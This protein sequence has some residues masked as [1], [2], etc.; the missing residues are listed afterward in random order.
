MKNS[1]SSNG[2][3]GEQQEMSSQLDKLFED[4]IRDIYWAEKALVKALPKMAKNATSPDLVAG[5]EAHLAE[6]EEQVQRLEQIF[7]MLGKQPRGK[8]CEAMEGLIAEG[9]TH[10][11]E[12]EEGP[13]RD[14]AII[15]SAQKVEHYEISA[16]G[17]LRTYAET[18][19]LDEAVTILDTTLSE[20]KSTDVKLTELAVTNINLLAASEPEQ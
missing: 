8:K 14:A 20:E 2:V 5:I 11:E 10:M 9:E 13:M 1:K 17:T 12:T 7:E 16:Y 18:L 15:A 19:G 4:S 3:A 6:T